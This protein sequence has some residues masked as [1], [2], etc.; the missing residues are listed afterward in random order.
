MGFTSF[1]LFDHL[2]APGLPDQPSFEG[3]TLATALLA[4]TTTL[5]VG[6]LVLN[7]NL[8][9]PAL[10]ARMATTLDVI[11]GGRLKLG[12]GSGSFAA[13]HHEGGFPWGSMRERT[14]RLEEALEIVTRMFRAH[15]GPRGSTTRWPTPDLPRPSKRRGRRSTSAA[16]GIARS[17]SWPAT[18]TCGTCRPTPSATGRRH[19]L[20]LDEACAAVER[21]PAS[22]GRSLEAVLVIARRSSTSWRA[23][24]HGP[25]DATPVEGWGLGEG[26]CVGTPAALVDRIDGRASA[27]RSACSC[28]SRPTAAGGR[29]DRPAGRGG[30]APAGLK[31]P[32]EVDLQVL[33][34]G[35]HGDL[36]V[37]RGAF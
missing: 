11:S 10:L 5:R 9:H 16:P 32:L 17:G 35:R 36:V 21:D 34:H 7:N 19:K 13:E 22:V 1:W 37:H 6:H 29:H 14:D 30:H 27:A 18:P 12:I 4:G 15:P 3:W 8:R 28:S 20:A 2:Y 25:N 23:H 31:R 26:G 33:P 24:D